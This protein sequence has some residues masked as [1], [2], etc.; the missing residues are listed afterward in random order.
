MVIDWLEVSRTFA[1]SVTVRVTVYVPGDVY[2]CVGFC[3]VLIA[4]SPNVQ[5]QERSMSFDVDSSVNR[6]D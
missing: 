2:V 6:T 4:L 3:E 5:S 1:S